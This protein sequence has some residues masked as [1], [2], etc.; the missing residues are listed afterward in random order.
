MSCLLAAVVL[1][2]DADLPQ[3]FGDNIST[4][5]LRVIDVS[6]AILSSRVAILFPL[7]WGEL[8]HLLKHIMGCH[9]NLVSELFINL[10]EVLDEVKGHIVG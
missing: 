10:G 5:Q 3:V 2:V 8:G 9:Q 7:F 4:A 6:S 1:I